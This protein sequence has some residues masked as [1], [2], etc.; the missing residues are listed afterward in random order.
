[1]SIR[2]QLLG[3]A[4]IVASVF[5]VP[6]GYGF[7]ISILA[8]LMC[9]VT[10]RWVTVGVYLLLFGPQTFG[11]IADK[12]DYAGW[13]GPAIVFVGLF[14]LNRRYPL[15][16]VFNECPHGIGLLFWCTCVLSFFYVYGLQNSYAV[17]LLVEFIKTGFLSFVGF[18][19]I[20]R[21]KS[22]N[23]QGLGLMGIISGLIYL[24][25]AA[26]IDPMILPRSILDIGRLHFSTFSDI[27][28]RVNVTFFNHLVAYLPVVGYMFLYS[29]DT[30]QSLNEKEKIIWFASLFAVTVLVGWSGARQ[31]LFSLMIGMLSIFLVSGKLRN[32]RYF[33]WVIVG[34]FLCA[35][36]LLMAILKD[37]AMYTVLV[38]AKASILTKINRG[39]NFNSSWWLLQKKPFLG[40]GLGGYYI[41]GYSKPGDQVFAHN[42]ILDLLAQT[43]LIGTLSFFLPIL[44]FRTFRERIVLTRNL[45]FGNSIMPVFVVI[46]LRLLLDVHLGDIGILIGMIAAMRPDRDE[47][48]Q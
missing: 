3:V 12:F 18:Y 4:L 25:V 14:I 44:L 39:E 2:Y 28:L 43:G 47:S 32:G 48:E 31:G 35:G 42:V 33:I 34:C 22:V 17:Y 16:K 37:M 27:G 30:R 29:R 5:L 7:Y 21:D 36:V 6:S 9:M 41:P 20:F 11:F 19:F 23:W 13:G 8:L 1:M 10:Y 24:S 45:V 46:V 38:D 40:H 26:M 15:L